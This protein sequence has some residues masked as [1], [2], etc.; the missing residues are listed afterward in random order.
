[1]IVG[2]PVPDNPIWIN[3]KLLRPPPKPA[4][5]VFIGEVIEII[6]IS[7]PKSEGYRTDAEALKIKVTENVYSAIQITY[8]EALPLRI[9][10]DCSLQGETDLKQNFPVGSKVRVIAEEAS[11][12]KKD[13]DDSIT[14]LETSVKNQGSITR[15]DL[16]ESLQT[17]ANSFYDYSSFAV[18]KP[19]TPEEEIL[20]YSKLELLKFELQKDLARLLEAKTEDER[21]KVMERL[22][23]YPHIYAVPYHT[24]AQAYLMNSEKRKALEAKWEERKQEQI[25]LNNQGS[26]Q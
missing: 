16:D 5:Y 14:R 8:F 17:S 2:L 10:P 23:Y 11:I 6:K 3:G 12:Y 24:L 21:L 20:F 15:N 1:M 19:T 9:Y 18:K 4:K 25:R 26:S 13:S 7:K 22:V